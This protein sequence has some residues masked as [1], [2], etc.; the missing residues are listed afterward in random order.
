M[1]TSKQIFKLKQLID[2]QY[3]VQLQLDSLPVL[4]RS[5]ELNYA[6][7][8]YPVGFKA[9]TGAYY[10]YNHLRFDILYHEDPA[11]FQGIRITGF[12]VHP[13]SFV[14]SLQ[15]IESC[16][17]NIKS[18]DNFPDSYLLLN[19]QTLKKKIVLSYEVKW[20]QNELTWAD[21]WDVYLV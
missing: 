5:K 13:V 8:G 9:P 7:R 2:R 19:E 20:N 11:T 16:N 17:A 12:D 15:E 10:L 6:A 1:G 18:I 4:M 3:R 21:R 14:H